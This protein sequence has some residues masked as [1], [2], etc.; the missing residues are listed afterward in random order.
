[1][2]KIIFTLILALVV[3]SGMVYA[4]REIKN[5]PSKNSMPKPHSAAEKKAAEDAAAA[6]L[7]GM[8]VGGG[9]AVLAGFSLAGDADAAAIRGTGRYAHLEA[10][11]L[12]RAGLTIRGL[13]RD[14]PL[15]EDMG[16]HFLIVP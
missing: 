14:G 13:Q 3:V 10:V 12:H 2:K 7:R 5:E 11:G 1:M 4:N 8:A 9:A 6:A 16:Q 15:G